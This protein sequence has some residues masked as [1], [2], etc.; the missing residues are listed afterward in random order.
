MVCSEKHHM[1]K[2][3]LNPGLFLSDKGRAAKLPAWVY[4]I[5]ISNFPFS[6]NKIVGPSECKLCNC[7]SSEHAE[8]NKICFPSFMQTKHIVKVLKQ[9]VQNF[10]KTLQFPKQLVS[11]RIAPKCYPSYKCSSEGRLS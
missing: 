8:Q 11:K 3:V 10:R 1:L 5:N 7:E 4:F 2:K 9:S 6:Q